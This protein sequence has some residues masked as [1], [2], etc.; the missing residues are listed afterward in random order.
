MDYKIVWK[1]R[2]VLKERH[3]TAADLVSMRKP[4][5]EPIA[6]STTIYSL[7]RGEDQPGTRLSTLVDIAQAIGV[8]ASDLFEVQV[9]E[10]EEIAA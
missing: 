10:V 6:G 8:Q 5:G 7:Y 2:K 9:A 4:D 3:M 1:L